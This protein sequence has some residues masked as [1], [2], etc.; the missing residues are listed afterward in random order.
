MK[1]LNLWMMILTVA[2]TAL[3]GLTYWKTLAQDINHAPVISF[4]TDQIRASVHVTDEELLAGVAAADAEDGDVTASVV[5]EGISEFVEDNTRVVTYAAFDSAGNVCKAS[6]ELVYTDYTSP[7]F[8]VVDTL[9]FPLNSD[10]NLQECIH[11]EDIIDGD[12]TGKIRVI[13]SDY[14]SYT[15][16]TYTITLQV[17]NSCG[18]TVER[19]FVL[20]CIDPNNPQAHVSEPGEEAA[21]GE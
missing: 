18:D 9:D 11:V 2:A 13:Q 10:V 1:R 21:D 15:A 8:S 14:N 7:V 6:R 5:I 16:G 20:N 19:D 4:D 3:F 17:T 12:I